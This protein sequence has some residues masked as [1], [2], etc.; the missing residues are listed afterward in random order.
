ME[1]TDSNMKTKEIREPNKSIPFRNK[2]SD[3][4]EIVSKLRTDIMVKE[5]C[6][7]Q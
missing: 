7:S 3:M 4:T 1:N 2:S 5:K 6:I